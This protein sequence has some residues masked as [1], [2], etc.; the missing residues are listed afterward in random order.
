MPASTD[1]LQHRRLQLRDQLL[2]T[3]PE[4]CDMDHWFDDNRAEPG[5]YSLT[6]AASF[7]IEAC[8]TTACLAGHGALIMV[9]EGVNIWDDETGGIN[10]VADHYGLNSSAFWFSLWPDINVGDFNLGDEYRRTGSE[11]EALIGYLDVLIKGESE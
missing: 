1:D 7:D 3:G 2:V 5:A 8:G 11:W 6:D 4:H 9:R 10:Q